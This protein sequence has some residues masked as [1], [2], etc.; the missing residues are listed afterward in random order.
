MWEEESELAFAMMIAHNPGGFVT[1]DHEL[2][3]RVLESLLD[4]GHEPAEL[5]PMWGG[6]MV[7][8]QGEQGPK[9]SRW[10]K[11]EN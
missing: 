1:R 11:G 3:K 7:T 2:A 9:L 6:F 4:D 10:L 8:C 5:V